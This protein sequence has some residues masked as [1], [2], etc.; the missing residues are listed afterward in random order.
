MRKIT[1][2]MALMFVCVSVANAQTVKRLSKFV[3]YQ[4]NALYATN[5]RY[6]DDYGRVNKAEHIKADG[7]RNDITITYSADGKTI[8]LLGSGPSVYSD[9]MTKSVVTLENGRITKMVAD[10]NSTYGDFVESNNI[11]FDVD[12]GL[13][14]IEASYNYASGRTE[15]PY[16]YA[17]AWSGGN[18]ISFTVDASVMNF[19]YSAIDTPATFPFRMD[20]GFDFENF[21][22][23]SPLNYIDIKYFGKLSSKL[24]ASTVRYRDGEVRETNTISYD[25]DGNGDVKAIDFTNTYMGTTTKHHLDLYYTDVHTGI[26]AVTS[27]TNV[28]PSRIY[29]VSGQRLPALS[30]GLNIIKT[31]SGET[32][33]VI[34]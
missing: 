9:V 14:Q 19:T 26:D 27:E 24:P 29:N 8:T 32:I 16:T 2:I 34:K 3:Y 28:V 1:C 30:N 10:F 25:L 33:K 4:N 22:S 6:Y 15:G 20:I 11:I 5:N 31:V 21:D 17:L 7:T 12:G 13:Q 18:I 23:P